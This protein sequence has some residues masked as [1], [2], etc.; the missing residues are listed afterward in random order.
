MITNGFFF[1]FSLYRGEKKEVKLKA[2]QNRR[3]YCFLFEY[4]NFKK[5]RGNRTFVSTWILLLLL[6]ITKAKQQNRCKFQPEFEINNRSNEYL[7]HM[8]E[9]EIDVFYVDVSFERSSGWAWRSNCRSSS[10]IFRLIRVFGRWETRRFFGGDDF[11]RWIVCERVV[12]VD[13]FSSIF[14]GFTFWYL[15]SLDNDADRVRFE[16]TLIEFESDSSSANFS[17]Q[18]LS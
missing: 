17:P 7:L 18:S 9:I 12:I 8:N 11:R 3:T 15:S 5:K 2:H 13:F 6:L 4:K 1:V 10:M 14:V 16:R